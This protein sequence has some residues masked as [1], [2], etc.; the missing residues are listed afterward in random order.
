MAALLIDRDDERK[1]SFRSKES[2]DCNSFAR[3]Y[4]NGGGHY[5]A[6]GGRSV[7]SLEENIAQFKKVLK[8]FSSLQQ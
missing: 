4:F 6:S 8:E 1:W 3:K 2:F 7:E 5:N